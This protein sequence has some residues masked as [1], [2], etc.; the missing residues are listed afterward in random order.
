M[1]EYA[2]DFLDTFKFHSDKKYAPKHIFR[3]KK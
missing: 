2:S 1:S 3:K